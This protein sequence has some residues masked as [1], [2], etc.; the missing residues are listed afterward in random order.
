MVHILLPPTLQLLIEVSAE[1]GKEVKNKSFLN[2][3][4]K[5]SEK[6]INI[7]QLE[8]R[9]LFFN[10]SAFECNKMMPSKPK[11]SKK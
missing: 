2:Q 9:I 7:N 4:K 10:A 8:D 1:K 3:Y 6:T 11:T 5:K